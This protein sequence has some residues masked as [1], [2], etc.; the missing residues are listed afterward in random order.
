MDRGSGI[1]IGYESAL[2][3]WRS[4]RAAGGDASGMD[5]AVGRTYG[6]LPLGPREL[7][8]RAAALCGLEEPIDIVVPTGAERVH[9]PHFTS[10]VCSAPLS[11]RQCFLVDN[12]ILVSPPAA[13]LVQLG[14]RWDV[15]E[16]ARIAY[17]LAGTYGFGPGPAREVVKDVPALAS[18]SELRAYASAAHAVGARGAARARSALDLVVSGSNSPRETDV[19]IALMTSR[20]KGGFS[21]GG[22]EMNAMVALPDAVQRVVGRPTLRPDFFWRG[23]RLIVEYES[24]EYHGTPEAMERDERRRRAF[25]GAG[26]CFRRLTNDVVSSDTQLNIFMTELARRIDPNRKP[27]TEAMLAKRRAFRARLFGPQREEEAQQDLAQPY[28]GTVL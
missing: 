3:F 7:A 5:E 12:E 2:E 8:S 24:D 14:G 18:V 15:I 9:S 22:F 27:A 26:Y 6:R 11:R 23:Q 13:V 1:I 16:L 28:Q 21:L 25:E 4:V 19:A 20:A 17:E 10:R